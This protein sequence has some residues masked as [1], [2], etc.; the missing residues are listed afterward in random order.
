VKDGSAR[1][2]SEDIK[3]EIE[4]TRKQYGELFAARDILKDKPD[5]GDANTKVGLYEVLM[6]GEIEEGLKHLK[7]SGDPKLVAAAS[8]E[9]GN[10]GDFDVDRSLEIADAWF[11][12][13]PGVELKFKPLAAYKTAMFYDRLIESEMLADPSVAE[14]ALERRESMK[15]LAGTVKP[16]KMARDLSKVLL[17][18]ALSGRLETMFGGVLS[19]DKLTGQMVTVTSKYT[20]L[21]PLR[22]ALG[23][24]ASGRFVLEGLA[25]CKQPS[26]WS[27]S[28]QLPNP[29]KHNFE[30]MFD[31][32]EL[33]LQAAGSNVLRKSGIAVK[34]GLHSIRMEFDYDDTVSFLEVKLEDVSGVN[35]RRGIPVPIFHNAYHEAMIMAA[36]QRVVAIGN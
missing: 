11:Q 4:K 31:G 3:K 9:A 36:G 19:Q 10:R 14:L 29:K 21:N 8:L 22:D 6:F 23:R 26:N 7:K 1:K 34:P 20:G 15:K 35:A 12:A 30:L 2:K 18:M 25:E 28:V 13:T 24:K 17:E 5:D 32:E 27:V 33:E 16:E